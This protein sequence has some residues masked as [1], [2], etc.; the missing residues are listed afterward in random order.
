LNWIYSVIAPAG[1]VNGNG[2]SNL[3][4]YAR[5]LNKPAPAGPGANVVTREGGFLAITYRKLTTSSALHYAIKKSTDLI[6]WS[7]TT[8]NEIILLSGDDVQ[9]IKASVPITGPRMFLRL[10]ITE[11]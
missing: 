4:D 6:N 3:L 8:P 1:D 11:S 7:P 2:I 9:L 5:D 10:E